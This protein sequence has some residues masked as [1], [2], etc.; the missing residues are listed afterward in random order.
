MCLELKQRC[1]NKAQLRQWSLSFPLARGFVVA[2]VTLHHRR[3]SRWGKSNV[4]ELKGREISQLARSESNV[5][6]RGVRSQRIRAAR[7][8]GWH[9]AAPLFLAPCLLAALLGRANA[10]DLPPATPN[11]ETIAAGSLVI[12]MDNDNQNIGAPFNLRAYGLVQRLLKAQIPVKWAIRAGKSKDGI[13]FS[14]RAERVLPTARPASLLDFRGG[15]FVVEA[16]SASAALEIASSYGN[17]VAL[18]RL[19]EPAQ[20]DVRYTLMQ[21]A[22]VF[23]AND[24][25]TADVHTAVLSAAGFVSGEDYSVLDRP[26]TSTQLNGNLCATIVTEPHYDGLQ[27]AN[28]GTVVAAVREFVLSGGNVLAQCKAIE[29]YENHSTYGRFQTSGGVIKPG[30]P[31]TPFSYLAPDM[32]FSQFVGPLADRGGAIPRYALASGSAFHHGG[33]VHVE[34]SGSGAGRYKASVSKLGSGVGSLVFYLAG[35]EYP[36]SSLEEINGRRMYLNAVFHPARRPAS[37]GFDI[38][39]PT[40]TRSATPQVTDPVPLYSA[41]P[42]RSATPQVTDPV[43]LYSATPTFTPNPCGNG[44]LDPGEE[45]DDGN[46]VNGDC[47]SATCRLD[48]P[49]A[50]CED[51]LDCT[52]GDA[53]DA[54][55]VCRSEPST[56]QYA[57]LRWAPTDPVGS[58]TT[59]LMRRSLI[60]GHVCSDVVRL[61]RQSRVLGDLV[62]LAPSGNALYFGKRTQVAGKVVTLG[63]AVV[64]AENAS[65]GEFLGADSTGS[66]PPVQDCAEARA[67]TLQARQNLLSLPNSAGFSFG[68]TKV[69]ARKTL[70]LPPAGELD[71]GTVVVDFEDL[72]IGSSGTL[73]LVGSAATEDVVIRVR[74]HL[75]LGRRAK[76]L[77]AGL[78][79]NQVVLAVDGRTIIGGSAHLPGTLM[80]GDRIVVRRRAVVEGGLFGR[81]V[82]VSG[83]AR[84]RRAGWV[85][86]C[87]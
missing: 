17:N 26:T 85:G 9:F 70:R 55:G 3:S 57:I 31:G 12:P 45:C 35:H 29:S 87:R 58:F 11:I 28:W 30:N 73:E 37:C 72:K 81:S 77:L 69:R 27:D 50:P 44:E 78:Q 19:V 46:N 48:P 36:G 64:G 14:A 84:V 82:L 66:T 42:T 53:C 5:H 23:V 75:R 10:S 41:T 56:G 51:G 76:L 52:E 74:N 33:H 83:S 65:M 25:G 86:W 49:G 16:S 4:D 7:Q 67:R 61:A 60:G 8:R 20:V 13:D 54:F 40:P 2:S 1:Y 63:G 80:G 62:A 43:P 39:T 6:D 47:C 21:R 68:V 18:Y 22:F 71:G 15:P 38:P 24:G 59:A 32:G 34:H 79:P